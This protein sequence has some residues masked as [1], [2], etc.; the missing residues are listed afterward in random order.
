MRLAE[1]V[2]SFVVRDEDHRESILGD[3]REEH[4]KQARRVGAERIG[5]ERVE[6]PGSAHDFPHA[7]GSSCAP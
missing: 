5:V 7:T 4:A 6:V 2:V 1:Q 3:L